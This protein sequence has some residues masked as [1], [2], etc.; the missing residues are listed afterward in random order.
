MPSFK[1]LATCGFIAL[2][3]ATTAQAALVVRSVGTGAAAFPVGRTVA[4]GTAI[5][6]TAGDMLTLLDGQ[7]TRTFRGPGTFDLGRAATATTTLAA[8]TAALDART[9]ARKPRL[10]TVRGI[11]SLGNPSLWDID[12]EAG[13][14]ATK[15]CVFD[16]SNII[17]RRGNTA[18]AAS[19]TISPAIGAPAQLAFEA[20]TAAT[21]WPRTL[22]A[23]G[24][25]TLSNGVTKRLVILTKVPTPTGDATTD[26]NTLIKAGCTPQLEKFVATLERPITTA[27]K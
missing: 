8:A 21:P 22:P 9:T 18:A 3:M 20:G 5:A 6:L 2:T 24:S 27:G 16:A 10:G 26:A 4:P 11:P 7:T 13:S 17:V 25:Y 19:L 23:S 15:H 14:T 1:S 12:L